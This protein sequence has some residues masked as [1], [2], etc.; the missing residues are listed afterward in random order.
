MDKI[1]LKELSEYREDATG[2][3]NFQRPYFAAAFLGVI[4]AI[5]GFILIVAEIEARG[6]HHGWDLTVMGKV[7]LRFEQLINQASMNP[8][9]HWYV[10]A[11][12]FLI[13]LGVF[14]STMVSMAL[15]TPTSR[16][17]G[18]K[19]EKYW[20]ADAESGSKE[21]VYVDRSAKTYFRRVYVRRPKPS[22]IPRR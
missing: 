2:L 21:I 4:L 17:S 7:W 5:A 22:N 18:E 1:R 13:G 3:R 12:L 14:L 6:G 16:V 19:L 10:P 8:E 15:A 9:I 20:S 11:A